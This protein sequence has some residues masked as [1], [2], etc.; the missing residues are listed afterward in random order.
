MIAIRQHLKSHAQLPD[1]NQ[2]FDHRRNL[3]ELFGEVTQTFEL[4]RAEVELRSAETMVAEV[5]SRN[6]GLLSSMFP[7]RRANL[8]L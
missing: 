2:T 4:S 1:L 8:V 5:L 7:L 6:V 3:V